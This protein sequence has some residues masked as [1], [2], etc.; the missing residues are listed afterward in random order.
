MHNCGWY[1][2]DW[3]PHHNRFFKVLQDWCCN[4]GHHLW[5]WR[6]AMDATHHWLYDLCFWLQHGWCRVDC[7]SH[8]NRFFE[9]LHDWSLSHHLWRWWNAMD[10]THHWHNDLCFWLQHGW[11][12]VNASRCRVFGYWLN[13]FVIIIILW[14]NFMIRL[15]YHNLLFNFFRSR[16]KDFGIKIIKI[17]RVWLCASESR[18]MWVFLI[19]DYFFNKLFFVL[20]LFLKCF[21]LVVKFFDLGAL[22]DDIS[23]KE[24]NLAILTIDCLT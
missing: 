11:C 12:S 17:L 16:S 15:L 21:L 19:F 9:V 23:P 6:D 24:V 8:R 13:D 20:R 5:F 18:N 2:V 10:A 22:F 3:C 1:M 7:C 4:V 14:L